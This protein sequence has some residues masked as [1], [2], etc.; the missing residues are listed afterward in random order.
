MR[1]KEKPDCRYAIYD[2]RADGPLIEDRPYSDKP[3]W[4]NEIYDLFAPEF[5]NI[6]YRERRV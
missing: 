3:K 1:I 4:R 6:K 5:E 2:L